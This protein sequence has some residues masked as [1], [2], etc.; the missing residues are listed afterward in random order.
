MIISIGN[1]C[2]IKVNYDLYC[3]LKNHDLKAT[4]YFDY[5]ISSF[6]GVNNLLINEIDN[7]LDKKN[8]INEKIIGKKKHIEFKLLD[9][10]A[11]MHDLCAHPS[12]VYYNKFI[13][14]YKRRYHRFYDIIKK[15]KIIHFVRNG[16]INE[17][18][19]YEF[20][21]NLKNMNEN[22]NY[23]LISIHNNNK[24]TIFNNNFYKINYSSYEISN[25]YDKWYTN[26]DWN[27]LF[28]YILTLS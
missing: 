8:L 17:K 10:S 5:L 24:N 15:E 25:I 13:M 4:N 28:D 22:I 1:N 2:L 21:K 11:S 3:K 27:N 14:K 18:E 12:Q 20:D 7:I 19:Y 9:N 6:K 23:Y 26:I 16:E